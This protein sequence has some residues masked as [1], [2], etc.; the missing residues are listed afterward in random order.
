MLSYLFLSCVQQRII[1]Q[2]SSVPFPLLWAPTS[3][4]FRNEKG[5]SP[6][7]VQ[8][9]SFCALESVRTSNEIF[10]SNTL[11]VRENPLVSCSSVYQPSVKNTAS[12][13]TFSFLLDTTENPLVLGNLRVECEKR[14]MQTSLKVSL[15]A[16]K[17]SVLSSFLRQQAIF[18]KVCHHFYSIYNFF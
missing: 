10:L 18:R 12:K 15:S 13:G 17:Y 16:L 7:F 6:H 3:I 5:L 8:Y 9:R 4:L 11:K 2:T 14:I 1:E